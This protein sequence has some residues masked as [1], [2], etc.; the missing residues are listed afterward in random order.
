[1]KSNQP[2]KIYPS[3]KELA[4]KH[5]FLPNVPMSERTS[6]YIKVTKK[7]NV[8]KTVKSRAHLS[9]R[10]NNVLKS[11]LNQW[12]LK[13]CV[14]GSKGIKSEW[15]QYDL[16]QATTDLEMNNYTHDDNYKRVSSNKTNNIREIK[17]RIDNILSF[18]IELELDTCTHKFHFIEEVKQYSDNPNIIE[19]KLSKS[20][21]K[22]FLDNELQIVPLL[23]VKGEYEQKI[24][25][26]LLTEVQTRQNLVGIHKDR[27]YRFKNFKI[28]HCVKYMQLITEYKDN[29]DKIRRKISAALK[30]LHRQVNMKNTGIIIPK[31][32]YK[33]GIYDVKDYCYEI[34]E[35]G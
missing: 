26:F 10:D 19:I 31:Y 32:R 8:I 20:F 29:P 4:K 30:S 22:T 25:D 34:K 27:K 13:V 1:M 24:L 28:E 17:R 14:K 11:I 3:N 2:S 33:N 6:E 15:L 18:V 12:Y 7:D 35:E 16:S 23:I 9:Q 21:I 5:N